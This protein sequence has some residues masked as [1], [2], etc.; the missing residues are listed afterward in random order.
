MI[1]II[2]H[3]LNL[4]KLFH[5]ESREFPRNT[6]VLGE[7]SVMGKISLLQGGERA[8]ENRIFN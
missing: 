6:E 2:Q 1:E 5:R 7:R 3:R 4:S 8:F